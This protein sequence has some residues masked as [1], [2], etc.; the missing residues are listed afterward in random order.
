MNMINMPKVFK[1][2]TNKSSNRTFNPCLLIRIIAHRHSLG[3]T[4]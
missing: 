3:L 4:H 1:H 2:L